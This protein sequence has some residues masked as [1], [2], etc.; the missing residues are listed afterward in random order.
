[1]YGNKPGRLSLK[2]VWRR[3]QSFLFRLDAAIRF[4]F[5]MEIDEKK[6]R[7]KATNVM[8]NQLKLA[9]DNNEY[10]SNSLYLVNTMIQI[11]IDSWIVLDH[12]FAFL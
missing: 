4:F 9:S 10:R 1:M 12:N 7:P 6:K 3:R 8:I 2:H 5:V 11:I